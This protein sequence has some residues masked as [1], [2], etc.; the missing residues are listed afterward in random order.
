ML[1][2]SPSSMRPRRISCMAGVPDSQS[3]L[4]QGLKLVEERRDDGRING[5]EEERQRQHEAPEVQGE[6]RPSD[7]GGGAEA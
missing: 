3:H 2:T 6:V 7:L 4:G 5:H 1:N